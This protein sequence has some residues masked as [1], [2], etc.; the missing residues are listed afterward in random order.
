MSAQT[1]SWQG[2]HVVQ[3][4]LPASAATIG[5]LTALAALGQFAGNIYTPSLPSV[6]NDLGASAAAVQLTLAIFLAAFAFAQLIYGPLSDRWGRRPVLFAGLV[7]FLIGTL[8]CALATRLDVLLIARGVQAL[9]AA[10]GVVVSR[11]VTRDCFDGRELTRVLA[12]ISIAFAAVPGLTPL[13]GGVVE[14]LAGWRATFG[15]TCIAGLAVA[16]AAWRLPET[17]RRRMSKLNLRSAFEGYAA[18]LRDRTFVAYSV[19][20]GMA[21]ASMAAFFAGSPSLFI[22]RL[23][24]SP[25]EYGLYPPLS[26]MGFVVGG[27]ITRRLAGRVS[28]LRLATTG[29]FVMLIGAV[30]MIAA[31]LSG[32]THEFAFAGAM[33]VHVT[34][35]GVFLPTAIAAAL[36][37]FAAQAGTAASMQGF[38]QMSGAALGALAVSALQPHLPMVAFPAVM[39]T[40]TS[41]GVL[42]LVIQGRIGDGDHG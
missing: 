9:G 16:T 14:H 21:M 26:V 41:L 27:V 28:A 5:L 19:A 35:L 13:L 34:G 29:I 4:M 8:G 39:L 15:V 17:N 1:D 6:A 37:R 11:A 40:A 22:D 38:L 18:T 31:P 10:A 20:A 3:R 32:V 23:G 25:I 2:P 24:V 12:T 33:I 42:A 7:I 36:Q 30:A